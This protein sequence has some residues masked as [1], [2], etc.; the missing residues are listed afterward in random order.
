MGECLL[1][2]DFTGEGFGEARLVAPCCEGIWSIFSEDETVAFLCPPNKE[3][4]PE[5]DAPSAPVAEEVAAGLVKVVVLLK[6][7][8]EE[9]C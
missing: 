2:D 8:L 5:V 9:V 6:L 7:E 4:G 1:G 3:R